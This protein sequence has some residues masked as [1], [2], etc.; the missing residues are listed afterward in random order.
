MQAYMYVWE[1]EFEFHII[2]FEICCKPDNMYI[3]SMRFLE[4]KQIR[5]VEIFESIGWD[6]WIN[7]L[8]YFDSCHE[9]IFQIKPI[10]AVECCCLDSSN[11]TF[12][13]HSGFILCHLLILDTTS[14]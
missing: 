2:L 5:L 3:V 7:W 8:R 4:K 1:S 9:I 13:G 6:I 10:V 11:S 12:S 14:L